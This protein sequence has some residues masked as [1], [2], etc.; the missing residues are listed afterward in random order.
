MVAPKA[1]KKSK[2]IDGNRG[3]QLHLPDQ[4]SVRRRERISWIPK[5]AA[6]DT[7]SS[8][9]SDAFEKA[10]AREIKKKKRISTMKQNR[11]KSCATKKRD[12]TKKLL[13]DI[14]KVVQAGIPKCLLYSDSDYE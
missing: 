6:V 11:T 9:S 13:F 2:V 8:D 12:E 3:K 1:L 4:K 5:I 10:P 7:R 14:R